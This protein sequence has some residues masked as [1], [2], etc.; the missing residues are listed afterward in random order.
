MRLPLEDQPVLA[1]GILWSVVVL[2]PLAGLAIWSFMTIDG[3]RMAFEP[4]L[5][6]YRGLLASGR[7][8]VIVRTVRIAATVTII[9][10]LLAFPFALW[11]AKWARSPT[12]RVILLALLTVPFFLSIAARVIVWRAILGANGLVNAVLMGLGV[13][14]APLDWLLFSEFAVH[15][16]MIGPYFPSMFFPIF[17]AVAMID[18]DLLEASQDLGAGFAY[19]LRR[20]VLPL[21]APGI[22]AGILF[23]FIPILGDDVV[24]TML[25]GGNVAL[26]ANSV[27]SLLTAL[28][29]SVAAAVSTMVLG[30]T[31]VLVLALWLA[32]PG[33]SGIGAIFESLRR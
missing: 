21:A 9:E 1:F 10:L 28:N 17:L 5:D 12:L 25:G 8:E 14:D 29:Y 31:A 30:A 4:N 16:G 32:V 15:F 27:Q 23:T 11:L 3:F 19:T 18:D 7:W 6:A 20:V 26:L 2:V 24:A 13:T 33:R 22:V